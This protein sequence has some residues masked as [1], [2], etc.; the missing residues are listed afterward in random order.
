MS[1]TTSEG[2]L[3]TH[4]SKLSPD[5][6]A[7]KLPQSESPRLRKGPIAAVVGI[8]LGIVFLAISLAMR[9]PAATSDKSPT[10]E[11]TATP[12]LMVPEILSKGPDYAD[13]IPNTR[14]ATLPSR[15][16]GLDGEEADAEFAAGDLELREREGYQPYPTGGPAQPTFDELEEQKARLAGLVV[17]VGRTPVRDENEDDDRP[18][19]T[20]AAPSGNSDVLPLGPREASKD[21]AD[22]NHQERKEQFL[23]GKSRSASL[24][25][26]VQYPSSP[27]EIQAGAIIPAALLTA[28]NSDLPGLVIAQVSEN[29]YDTVSGDHLLVPQGTRL[30]ARYDSMVAWGQ[31]RVLLCWDR[32]IRPDGTSLD[33][34]CAPATDLAGRSGVTDTVDNHWSRIGGTVALS[35]LLAAGAASSQGTVNTLRPTFPQLWVGGAAQQVNDVGQQ[36]TQKN[37]QIQPTIQV[38]QGFKVNVAVHRDLILPPYAR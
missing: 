11:Q 18:R 33:L 25:K 4:A 22:P 15:A 1:D 20:A 3:G 8:A 12:P 7:L 29:V 5:D 35:S 21:S 30:L 28:I 17:P 10:D 9:T 19:G 13:P 36:L 16:T 32:L 24:G 23:E 27:F 38:P 6:E 2:T 37:L 31:Q 14:G 34:D 26:Q